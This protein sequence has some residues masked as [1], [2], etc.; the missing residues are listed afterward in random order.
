M[1]DKIKNT[2]MTSKKTKMTAILITIFL[3]IFV[4]LYT[5]KK[6]AP[7]FIIGFFVPVAILSI[8]LMTEFVIFLFIFFMACFAMWLWALID[9]SIKSESFYENYPNE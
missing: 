1:N 7:K 9:T 8:Y 2:K 5:I 3:G 4:W 6:S